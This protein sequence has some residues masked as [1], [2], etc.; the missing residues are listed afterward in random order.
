M[1]ANTLSKLVRWRLAIPLCSGFTL[2]CLTSAL[3][4]KPLIHRINAPKTPSLSVNQTTSTHPVQITLTQQIG[5][6]ATI[7]AHAC[8]AFYHQPGPSLLG[9]QI[10]ASLTEATKLPEPAR[11]TH[12]RL[13]LL[14]WAATEPSAACDW[15][16]GLPFHE[17]TSFLGDIM[18]SWLQQD[19]AMASDWFAN[20]LLT[21]EK[22]YPETLYTETLFTRLSQPIMLQDLSTWAALVNKSTLVSVHH[23]TS[24]IQDRIFPDVASLQKGAELILGK[25]SFTRDPRGN[26]SSTDD[27]STGHQGWN[28]LHKQIAYRWYALDP[29]AARTWADTLPPRERSYALQQFQFAEYPR[30]TKAPNSAIDPSDLTSTSSLSSST[31][32]SQS[33]ATW[34]KK[35]PTQAEAYLDQ[36][37]WPADLKFRARAEA[38]TKE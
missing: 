22:S 12:L 4:R 5:Q 32:R 38:Y 13:L 25:T 30:P 17:R 19:L 6:A 33:W 10:T 14:K 31:D 20:Y 1:N 37:A 35:E 29:S 9:T 8:L 7:D 21:V 23:M 3:F 26:L 27:D 28:S 36:C 24:T 2:A 15:A 34:W 18:E 11:A 16:A